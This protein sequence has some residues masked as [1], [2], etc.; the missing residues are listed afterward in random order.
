MVYDFGRYPIT[1]R[2]ETPQP[3][4]EPRQI[5]ASFAFLDVVYTPLDSK[6]L[7]NSKTRFNCTGHDP[8][9]HDRP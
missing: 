5:S 2:P 3:P 1:S 8:E 4:N 9:W 6:R 7:T